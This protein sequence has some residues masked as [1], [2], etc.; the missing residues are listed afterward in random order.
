[1]QIAND[2]VVRIGG[3][4]PQAMLDRIGVRMV[5]KDLGLP[6]AQALGA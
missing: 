5:E 3:N 4:P 1:M 6:N 2:V